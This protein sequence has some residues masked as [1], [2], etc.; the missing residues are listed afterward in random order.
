MEPS[1]RSVNE[2]VERRIQSWLAEKR[3][4]SELEPRVEPTRP[5]VTVSRLAGARGTE[6]GRL[7]AERMGFRLWDQELVQQV[8]G[9]HGSIEQ[10]AR[11]VD[12]HNHNAIEELLSSILLGD[13]FTG[14]G[15]VWRLRALLVALARK[16]S[17]VVVGRGAQFVVAHGT[18]LRIRVV[19]PLDARVQTLMTQRKLG[20]RAARAEMER[21]DRERLAF[22]KHQYHADA[23]DPAMYDLVV[24]SS[25]L[26][27][28]RAADIVLLAYRTKFP[29]TEPAVRAT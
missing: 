14:E 22:V 8:A 3:R 15:Y 17:A 13:A 7:V 9:G 21:L 24:N 12:E 2:I 20:E 4:R 25:S 10:M 27:L 6:L 28:E 5:I 29:P 16:G 19:A 18:A 11:V 26:T 1:P 23:A